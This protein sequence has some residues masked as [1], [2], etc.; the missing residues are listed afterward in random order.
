MKDKAYK[1]NFYF[2]SKQ[3]FVEYLLYFKHLCLE[4]KRYMMVKNK[5]TKNISRVRTERAS[6]RNQRSVSR[7]SE[8]ESQNIG[9]ESSF[10]ADGWGQAKPR[11]GSGGWGRATESY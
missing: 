5:Q 7:E 6:S 8:E 2:L 11:L 3:I 9:L 4:R 10:A 1:L